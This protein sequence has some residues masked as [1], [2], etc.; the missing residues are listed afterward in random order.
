[1]VFATARP[2]KKRMSASSTA[3]SST[4]ISFPSH[5]AGMSTVRRYQRTPSKAANSGSSLHLAGRTAV[6]H[7]SASAG[8]SLANHRSPMPGSLAFTAFHQ[9]VPSDWKRRRPSS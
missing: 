6:F 2:S 1:M 3:P 9:E 5:S 8:S 4:R 7:A